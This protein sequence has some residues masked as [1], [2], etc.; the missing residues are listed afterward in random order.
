MFANA[1]GSVDEAV[2]PLPAWSCTMVHHQVVQ[3]VSDVL[4]R[5]RVVAVEEADLAAPRQP[6]RA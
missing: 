4:L 6:S 3:R 2:A 1:L 5:R